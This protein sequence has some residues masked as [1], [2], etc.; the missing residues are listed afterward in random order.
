VVWVEIMGCALVHFVVFLCFYCMLASF[1]LHVI[2]EH[3][4]NCTKIS[5]DDEIIVGFISDKIQ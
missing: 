1:H 3:D 2:C 5:T 4:M